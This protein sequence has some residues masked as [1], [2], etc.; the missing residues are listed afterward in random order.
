M[1]SRKTKSLLSRSALLAALLPLAG[2]AET[3]YQ[4][5]VTV[6]EGNVYLFDI[7]ENGTWTQNRRFFEKPTGRN[8]LMH[9][10]YASD[11]VTYIANRMSDG[12]LTSVVHRVASDGTRLPDIAVPFCI[13]GIAITPDAKTIFGSEFKSLNPEYPGSTPQYLTGRVFKY[14]MATETWTLFAQISGE[15]NFRSIALDESGH[16]FV[17]DR[18]LGKVYFF[19]IG[20]DCPATPYASHD[21]TS[22]Q[23]ITWN[24]AENRVYVVG[25]NN[26][27]QVLNVDG[28]P[29]GEV[30]TATSG[31]PQWCHGMAFVGG[32]LYLASNSNGKI[33]KLSGSEFSVALDGG[34]S[35]L[36]SVDCVSRLL[37]GSTWHIDEAAGAARFEN[38]RSPA[39]P[40]LAQGGL[41]T[42]SGGVSGRCAFFTGAR[43][44]GMVANSTRLI[45]A[46]GDFSL[47]FWVALPAVDSDVGGRH[48]FSNAVGESGDF[49]LLADGAGGL[50][51]LGLSFT[52]DSGGGTVTVSTDAVVADGAWHNVGVIR[53]GTTIELWLDGVRKATAACS[54]ENAISQNEFWHLGSNAAETSGFLGA[55]ACLD[56]IV[57]VAEALLP[58]EA[59][60]QATSCTPGAVPASA[61]AAP[62]QGALPEAFGSEIA[63][64]PV[65]DN[66]FAAPSFIVDSHGGYWAAVGSANGAYAADAVTRV[67]RSADSGSTWTAYG[68]IAGNGISL[69]ESGGAICA[70]GQAGRATFKVWTNGVAGV[71][72]E[73]ASVDGDAGVTYVMTG[74]DTAINHDKVWKPFAARVAGIWR[75]GTVRF[76]VS[77]SNFS[78]GALSIINDADSNYFIHH[79]NT[80]NTT[81][82]RAL[83]GTVVLNGSNTKVFW[84]FIDERSSSSAIPLGPERVGYMTVSSSG[85]AGWL[86][87]RVNMFRGGSKPFGIKYDA[88][89]ETYWTVVSPVTNQ[90]QVAEANPADVIGTLAVYSSPDL[91]SWYPCGVIA[92]CAAGGF[93]A[94][95][96]AIDG[97]DMVMVSSVVADGAAGVRSADAGNYLAFRRIRNFRNAF[98]PYKPDRNRMFVSDAFVRCVFSYYC[99]PDGEWQPAGV[100]HDSEQAR[101]QWTENGKTYKLTQPYNI[102]VRNDK[103]YILDG[104]T[105]PAKIFVYGRK[106]TLVDAFIEPTGASIKPVGMDVSHNGTYA[107]VTAPG[108]NAVLKVDFVARTWT[109]VAR[110]DTYLFGPRS[111]ALASDGSFYVAN[112]A[113]GSGGSS[114]RYLCKFAADG[115]RL[116]TI[117]PG[118]EAT[119]RTSLSLDED[120]VFA[121][122]GQSSGEMTRINLGTLE[123][124]RFEAGTL[125]GS[126]WVTTA[127]GIAQ[128]KL[129]VTSRGGWINAYDL[130]TLERTAPLPTLN[131]VYGVGY[132]P[133]ERNRGF[134]IIFK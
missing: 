4:A 72:A 15:H 27:W 90:A 7:D 112:Y 47:F 63:H 23:G 20:D 92:D 34:W 98:K 73:A 2:L 64:T 111:L 124:L 81:F 26:Y 93:V 104:D 60:D 82:A 88:A 131:L 5:F 46:T 31:A 115:T 76:A 75:P 1:K 21:F 58:G 118:N 50:N 55:G 70:I 95:S 71:F 28:T 44:R 29:A 126:I 121:Y 85:T 67:Y 77:G 80:S 39:Q 42:A 62:A 94:T 36:W 101:C 65:Y 86:S 91:E 41:F 110:D 74:G 87:Y 100:L 78:G 79:Y 134:S 17:T 132:A 119:G 54:A 13:E 99:T 19:N 69:F 30:E 102:V 106:G 25:N 51:T 107:L 14:D 125:P 49:A 33:W 18:K 8:E 11:K 59:R 128:G 22:A 9:A 133:F 127:S 122:C 83:G 43:S 116:Q 123:T 109:T 120:G 105:T 52:P 68:T 45:P 113:G 129:F 57:F 10:V 61:D 84:P 66:P 53:R 56:E 38:V 103:V 40:I 108:S 89:S 16:L 48:L 3:M 35:K 24:K 97:D 37:T 114:K 32:V 130:D 12:A 117:L 96:F 6:H